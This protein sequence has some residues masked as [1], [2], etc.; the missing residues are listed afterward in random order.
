MCLQRL[1][2][3]EIEYAGKALPVFEKREAGNYSTFITHATG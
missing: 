1:P 2:A 3:Y